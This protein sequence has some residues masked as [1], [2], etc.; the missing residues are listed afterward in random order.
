MSGIESSPHSGT[1]E[2]S[3]WPPGSKV[4]RL[5]CG[6]GVTVAAARADAIEG[7]RLGG[8][9]ER[10]GEPFEFHPDETFFRRGSGHEAVVGSDSARL[11]HVEDGSRGRHGSA[12]S[13]VRG[14]PRGIADRAE[15]EAADQGK[16]QG[17]WTHFNSQ[18]DWWRGRLA[19]GT[20]PVIRCRCSAG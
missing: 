3:I 4:T 19:T 17:G 13:V 6:R 20:Q 12:R 10:D 2:S 7:G 15:L 18:L 16:A 9:V 14:D 1:D 8:V 11:G 5:A